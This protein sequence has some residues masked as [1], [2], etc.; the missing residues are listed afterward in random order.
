MNILD[1]EFYIVRDLSKIYTTSCFNEGVDLKGN[2]Y[3]NTVERRDD[4]AW[5]SHDDERALLQKTAAIDKW[6]R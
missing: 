1:R 4:S 2:A 3:N 5:R 6:R